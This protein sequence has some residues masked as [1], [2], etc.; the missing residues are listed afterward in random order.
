M[1]SGRTHDRITIWSLPWVTIATLLSTR[2]S[3]TTLIVSSAFLFSG[4]MFGPDLDIYSRQFQRWGK[5][6]WIWLPYQKTLRHRSL[7]SHGIAIGTGIRLVYFLSVLAMFAAVSMAIA[8]S[9]WGFDWNWQQFVKNSLPVIFDRYQ[10]EAIAT[11][12]GLELGAMSHSLSDWFHSAYKR[13]KKQASKK[14]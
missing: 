2:D 12:L 11:F 14:V 7:L 1:P 9:I 4:L 10:K 5:L 6:R 13:Q 8:Q 3:K